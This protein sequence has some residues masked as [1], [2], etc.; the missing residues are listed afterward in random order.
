MASQ[1][2]YIDIKRKVY[3]LSGLAAL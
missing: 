3:A 2:A 1:S